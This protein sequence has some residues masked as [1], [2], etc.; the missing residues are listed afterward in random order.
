MSTCD[1]RTTNLRETNPPPQA[2][3]TWVNGEGSF[4]GFDSVSPYAHWNPGEPNDG[5]GLEQHLGLNWFAGW[6]NDEANLNHITG[7]VVEYDSLQAVQR[8]GR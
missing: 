8:A 6:F 5:F 2:N 3:W 4:P 1:R 7:Y